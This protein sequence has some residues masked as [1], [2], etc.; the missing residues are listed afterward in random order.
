MER[1]S[2]AVRFLSLAMALYFVA[3]LLVFLV[4]RLWVLV[5]FFSVP[6]S[7][8][9]VVILLPSHA[10]LVLLQRCSGFQCY[11]GVLLVFLPMLQ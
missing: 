9:F 1:V 2:A 5:G 7:I 3:V 11:V 10:S 8:F 4:L 6:F